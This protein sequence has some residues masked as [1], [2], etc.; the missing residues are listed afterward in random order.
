MKTLHSAIQSVG[1]SRELERFFEVALACGNYMGAQRKTGNS[2]IEVKPKFGV[3]PEGI[4]KFSD[5]RGGGKTLMHALAQLFTATSSKKD[6]SFHKELLEILSR[7][8][9]IRVAN[10]DDEVTTLENEMNSIQNSLQQVEAMPG[11][12]G[13]IAQDHFHDVVRSF[14]QDCDV[15]SVKTAFNELQADLD[16][17]ARFYCFD[18]FKFSFT[19]M[20]LNLFL[21][22]MY[23]LLLSYGEAYD[24]LGRAARIMELRMQRRKKVRP[25]DTQDTFCMLDQQMET[26]MKVGL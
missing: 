15:T 20:P 4:L 24:D 7:A 1:S 10:L 3:R 5:C 26:A 25:E 18:P 12:M 9:Q 11:A 23:Q 21:S 19:E 13:D 17:V 6:G 8:N 2:L 22:D 14:L 16:T